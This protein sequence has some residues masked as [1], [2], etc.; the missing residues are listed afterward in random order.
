MNNYI[1]LFI[2]QTFWLSYLPGRSYLP[3]C[4]I[5]Q[6]SIHSTHIWTVLSPWMSY[7]P[8]CPISLTVLSPWRSYLPD[9]PISRMVLSPW[10]SYLPDGPISLTVLSPWWSYLPDCPISLT[11]GCGCTMGEH[12]VICNIF[13]C[14][15]HTYIYIYICVFSKEMPGTELWF[16]S[17]YVFM[18]ISFESVN[19]LNWF[20][21]YNGENSALILLQL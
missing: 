12:L 19:R 17:M 10:R 18:S 5:S 9:S 8:E 7:L 1:Y 11:S 4:P 15:Y 20:N 13:S 16:F 3:D 14:F 21:N 2:A 6:T